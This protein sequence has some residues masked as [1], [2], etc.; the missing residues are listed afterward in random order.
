MK[1]NKKRYTFLL[2]TLFVT[3][4]M[5]AQQNYIQDIDFNNLKID[6]SG[7]ALY[8]STSMNLSNVHLEGNRQIQLIPVLVSDDGATRWELPYVLIQG[9]TRN[10]VYRRKDRYN[11]RSE[12]EKNAKQIVYRKN[13]TAQTE[14]YAVSIPLQEGMKSATLHIYSKVTGCATCDIVENHRVLQRLRLEDY[15]PTY[16]LTYIVPEVEPV[17]ARS[18]K[19]A[20]YFNYK[21]ARHELLRNYKNNA[22]EFE[23]V[24]R[25]IQEIKND[26]DLTIT[27]FT[28]SGYASPEGSF[29]S[30]MALSQRRANSFA[31]YLVQTHNIPRNMFKVSWY[32]EDWKGLEEA[33]RK[34]NIADKEAVLSIIK[35]VSNPDARDARLKK[36]SGGATYA[37]LL[38]ELYPPLRRN[39]YTVAYVARAFNVEEA[40]QIIKTKPQLL[41]LNEMYL[42]A[43][44]YPANS[45]D[46]KEVFDIAVRMYP[47]EPIAIVN[48]AAADIESGNNKSAIARLKKIES[49]PRVWNNIGVAYARSGDIDNAKAYFQKAADNGDVDAKKNIEE[50]E[51]FINDTTDSH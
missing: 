45:G 13:N 25:V 14:P 34:S 7:R 43:Q 26:K 17:K 11:H 15:V 51:K 30:N 8:V 32:G 49:D 46:F 22:R 31:D 10:K 35:T 42:V 9:S 27:D 23:R 16:A 12:L 2:F 36:L 50:L 4:A 18:A 41:S 19:H 38:R 24:D 44:T 33:V 3:C 1:I 5:M 47:N 20:A 37:T 29:K 48:S 40:K 6:K 21:V 39:E 28:V